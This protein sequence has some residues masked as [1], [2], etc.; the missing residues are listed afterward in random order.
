MNNILGNAKVAYNQSISI[1]YDNLRLLKEINNNISKNK[2]IIIKANEK[3]IIEKKGFK[4][5]FNIIDSI[6]KENKDEKI[7]KS[8]ILSR[9]ENQITEFDS[10]GIID[11]F[12]DGNTYIL[13]E[14]A[15]KGIISHNAM[16][17]IS[18]VEYMK[19][20]NMAICSIIA[21]VLKNQNINEN[22]IQV[23]YDFN[24]TKYCSNDLIKKAFVIGNTDLHKT[25]KRTSKI[26]TKYIGYNDCD[27]Y[28][29]DADSIASLEKI[30]NNNKNVLFKIYVSKSIKIADDDDFIYVNDVDEA[31][32]KIKYDSCNYCCII[33]SKNKENCIKFAETNKA[34]YIVLNNT[35]DFNRI[36]NIDIKELYCK[37][38]IKK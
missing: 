2:N 26:D 19:Y 14:M 22:I 23:K 6:I 21:G 17:F 7:Y 10:L 28:I 32:E 27:I 18:Q 4:I 25:L 29:E 8:K 1:K 9:K 15:I 31:I 13:I 30:V 33:F 11:I 38:Y 37:K 36:N 24:L 20:T 16:I 35:M 5:N 12:F 3:D 34:K